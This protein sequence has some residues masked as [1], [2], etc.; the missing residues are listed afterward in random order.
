MPTPE[1]RGGGGE[2]VLSYTRTKCGT[3]NSNKFV[4]P[5]RRTGGEGER[6]KGPLQARLRFPAPFPTS[7]LP[8][9]LV[10]MRGEKKKRESLPLIK[11]SFWDPSRTE[12]KRLIWGRRGRKEKIGREE[13]KR[14]VP[15][16][17]VYAAT[18][19]FKRYVDQRVK[20]RKKKKKK[21][22]K[23][24]GWQFRPSNHVYHTRVIN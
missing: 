19:F 9:S 7:R 12:G 22:E 16:G 3:A 14:L 23:E 15:G 24:H 10:R 21:K 8:G 2:W 20:R 6:E 13:G 18:K 1:P 11:C 17:G 4:W 5:R